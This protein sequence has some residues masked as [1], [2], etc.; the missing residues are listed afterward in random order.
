VP[1]VSSPD[2]CPTVLA[3]AI[4]A[5]I[6]TSVPAPRRSR[7][8]RGGTGNDILCG[9]GGNDTLWGGASKDVLAGGPGADSLYGESG[10]D[11]LYQDAQDRVVNG[12][13]GRN[14][15]ILVTMLVPT[16]TPITPTVE[17]PKPTPTP[18]TPPS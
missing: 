3:L 6:P 15:I 17:I 5:T 14:E 2:T 16:A 7:R 9:F 11:V 1:L 8:D 4:G 10:D 13:S 12:G 18:V